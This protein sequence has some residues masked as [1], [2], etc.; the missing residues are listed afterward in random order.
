[1]KKI[2]FS[3]FLFIAALCH[4]QNDDCSGAI[5]LTVGTDF[6]S[7]MIIANNTGA[8][9]DGDLPSC[10]NNAVD[11]I[12]FTAVVPAS[13]NIKIETRTS[14]GLLTATIYSGICSSLTEISC[15]RN[16]SQGITLTGQTPGTT[17]YISVWKYYSGISN[18]E[19]K[20]SAYDPVPP[21]N[22]HCSNAIPLT[23]GTD[24]NS[25]MIIANNTEA[26]TDGNI[27]SCNNNA[28]ENIWFTAVV[29]PSGNIKIE[30]R[31]IGTNS[32]LNITTLVVYSGAC[33][34]LM[35]L[36]CNQ[37]G[38]PGI[39]LTGQTP[40]TTLYIS[41]WRYSTDMAN[42][43]FQISAFDPIPPANDNC[44]E[45]TSL[46]VGTDFN[47]GM[48]IA[49]NLQ[50][51]TDE[52]LPS[53]NADAAENIWFKATVPA[54]GNIKIETRVVN[55]SWFNNASLTVYS[56]ICGSLTEIECSEDGFPSVS[57]TGQTPGA[58]LYIS[59]WK[60][61][62]DVLSGELQISAYDTTVLSTH[63]TTDQK[64]KITLHPNPFHDQITISD[65]AKVKTVVV[66]DSSGR[67]IKTIENPA[68]TIYLNDLKAGMYFITLEIKDG[69][70][71]TIKTIKK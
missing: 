30:T 63:E 40:G 62:P 58:T 38:T 16:S 23:V 28:V 27:P 51:T 61:D 4:A 1:M 11:N 15:N 44:S 37:Y 17:L 59:V 14:G 68:A 64:K 25:G 31:P 19:F 29:P 33:D 55:S 47:S 52:N 2:L 22:D 39:L 43:N 6:N 50:A 26:T 24:F 57:L 3:L 9:T 20:I 53:C 10:N 13:G 34:S 66:S 71:E 7:G 5:S 36:E 45:A 65:I 32:L 54:S 67:L 42:G 70:A 41:A 69:T 18:G 60:H 56:G 8:T 48:M 21:A 46:T 49:N 12:W 35:E